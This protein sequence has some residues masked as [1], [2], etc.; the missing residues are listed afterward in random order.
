MLIP[1]S[2]LNFDKKFAKK[3]KIAVVRTNYHNDLVDNLEA[4]AR[5]TLIAAGVNEKNMET[6]RAPGSWEIPILVQKIAETKKIKFDG[7]IAFGVIVKGETFHFELIANEVTSALMQLS[8]DNHVPIAYEV[9]A[10]QDIKHA[11]ARAG[12]NDYN[13]GIE[14]ANALLQIILA[15]KQIPK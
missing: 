12:Q 14:A 11:H 13:K 6:F 9:L 15:L 2:V 8:I 3:L 4:Y 7:I 5:G 10:V 1:Q